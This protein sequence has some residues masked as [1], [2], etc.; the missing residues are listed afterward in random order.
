MGMTLLEQIK[1]LVSIQETDIKIDQLLKA[2]QSQPESLR[3]AEESLQKSTKSSGVIKNQL[4]ELEKQQ[5]QVYSALEMNR[6]R[7]QRTQG[8]L[9]QSGNTKEFQASNREMDQLKK[10]DQTLEEQKV[11]LQLEIEKLKSDLAKLAES[12]S[13][14]Q[15]ERDRAKAEFET[16]VRGMQVSVE[17]LKTQRKSFLGSVDPG[18]LSRYDRVRQARGGLGLVPAVSGRCKGC[19]MMISPQILNDLHRCKEIQSCSSC[20]RLLFMPE[21]SATSEAALAT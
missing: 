15:A 13:A 10:V 4:A 3:L 6:E 18:T 12:E 9:D 16:Q 14:A 8:R 17:E 20:H 5:R 7:T 21:S 19:N 2:M 1:G 11:K